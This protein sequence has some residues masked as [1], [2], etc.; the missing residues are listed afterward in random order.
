MKQFTSFVPKAEQDCHLWI[1]VIL[2]VL[3]PSDGHSHGFWFLPIVNTAAM[4]IS[5]HFVC[6]N[7]CFQF[8]GYLS[9]STIVEP[10]GNSTLI[11]LSKCQTILYIDY[12]IFHKQ[13]LRVS[14]SQHPFQNLLF[15]V[16]LIMVIVLCV[17][18]LV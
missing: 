8:W 17:K 16:F 2:F 6:L 13:G 10:Y 18:G 5:V 3:F 1:Y 9:R 14:V 7:Q 11:Y 4:N 12:T 15:L